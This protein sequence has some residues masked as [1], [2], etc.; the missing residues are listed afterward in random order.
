VDNRDTGDHQSN[1]R[2]TFVGVQISPISFVDEPGWTRRLASSS[3]VAG[4]AYAT[5]AAQQVIGFK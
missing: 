1:R 2:D 4:L 3:A 5:V